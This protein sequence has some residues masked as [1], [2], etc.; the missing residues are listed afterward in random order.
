MRR[1]RL[2]FSVA[3]V[4]AVGAC[5]SAQSPLSPSDAALAK[6]GASR[7]SVNGHANFTWE[8]ALQTTSFQARELPN[9]RVEG[10]LRL[11]ARGE[12]AGY[13]YGDASCLIVNGNEAVLG[14][15]ITSSDLNATA[16]VLKVRDNGEGA[17]SVDEWSDVGFWVDGGEP[18]NVCEWAL[19]R[20][21]VVPI[22]GGNIQVKP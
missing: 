2:L 1:T 12:Y 5:E 14:G 9:G 17:G 8:G 3:M 11:R 22:E 4:A 16:W 10:M 20:Y 18:E 19:T 13:L 21:G 15:P 7:P 6:G